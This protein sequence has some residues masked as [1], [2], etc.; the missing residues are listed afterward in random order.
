MGI[1][2]P[3]L[4]IILAIL[5]LIF[6]TKRLRNIGGDLGGAVK[7]F[8]KAM[9]T[10]EEKDSAKEETKEPG[11]IENQDAQFQAEERSESDKNKH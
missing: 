5:I 4:L 10:E 7:G 3:Q 2:I 9:S 11:K 6:G 1:S 8:R